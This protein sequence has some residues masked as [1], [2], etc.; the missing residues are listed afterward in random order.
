MFC[1]GA[2]I[3]VMTK[4]AAP[5]WA[6][7]EVLVEMVSLGSTWDVMVTEALDGVPI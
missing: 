3:A 1:V 4:E 2:L 5:P 6:T 7:V